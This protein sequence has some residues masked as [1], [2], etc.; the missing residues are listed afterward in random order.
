MKDERDV[1][2]VGDRNDGKSTK[3]VRLQ[4]G[5]RGEVGG[6]QRRFRAPLRQRLNQAMLAQGFFGQELRSGWVR[7]GA[8]SP[9]SAL[10]K[11]VPF[12]HATPLRVTTVP[13]QML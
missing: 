1:Q 12:A 13:H 7:F 4:E 5:K 8:Q 10:A 3:V 6:L 11:G 2:G 9:I